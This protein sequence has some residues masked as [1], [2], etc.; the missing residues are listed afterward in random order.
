MT[1]KV[2][3]RIFETSTTVGTGA[4]GLLGAQTGFQSFSVLLTGN[5]CPYFATDDINW[6][7]GIGTWTSGPSTLARTTILA[8]SNGG[9]AVNWGGGITQKIRCGLPSTLAMPR[10]I[11]KSVAG[12]TDVALS[13]NEQRNNIILLTGALTGNINVTVNATPWEWVVHNNT[14]GAFS[15]TFKVLGQTGIAVSQGKR[16]SL[17]C[18]GTDVFS[19]LTD[20]VGAPALDSARGVKVKPFDPAQGTWT[21]ATT[22]YAAQAS[23]NY[24]LTTTTNNDG[25]IVGDTAQFGAVNYVVSQVQTGAPVFAYEYW[26]GAWTALSGVSAPSFTALGLTQLRFTVPGDW[27]VGGSG[28]G[29]PAGNFN[30]RVRATTAPTQAVQGRGSLI[31]KA[32]VTADEVIASDSSGTKYR[33]T[34][35]NIAPDIRVAGSAANGRDQAGAFGASSWIYLWGI[36]N[37]TTVTWAGIWSASATAPTLPSGY[38]AVV[39]LAAERVDANSVLVPLHQYGARAWLDSPILDVNATTTTANRTART[40]TV[41]PGAIAVVALGIQNTTSSGI[42]AVLISDENQPDIAPS[43]AGDFTAP[44]GIT[45]AGTGAFGI[46]KQVH[47]NASSQAYDRGTTACTVRWNTIGWILSGVNLA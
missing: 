12:N 25:H 23:G 2:N 26:N 16:A 7:V 13:E 39:L 37:P 31:N 10:A 33:T 5:T 47:V 17:Y 34:T 4:Y 42:D 43:T 32:T 3:D 20:L 24:G 35:L 9:A 6:E 19:A 28:T 27:V 1:F 44:A 8:S 18:E 40:L 38:T 36:F 29:V 21:S 41:P 14:T 46:E 45:A 22:T 30:I 11:T 15:V